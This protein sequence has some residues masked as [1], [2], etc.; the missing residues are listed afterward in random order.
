MSRESWSPEAF[1]KLEATWTDW[2]AE[3]Q[4]LIVEQFVNELGEEG[5][6]KAFSQAVEMHCHSVVAGIGAAGGPPQQVI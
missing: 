6:M 2:D 5:A 3:G 1:T 4:R